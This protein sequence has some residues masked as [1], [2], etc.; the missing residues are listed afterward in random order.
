VLLTVQ[1]TDYLWRTNA[2]DVQKFRQTKLNDYNSLRAMQTFWLG[3]PKSV[4]SVAPFFVYFKLSEDIAKKWRYDNG[5]T[6]TFIESASWIAT[7]HNNVIM[8]NVDIRPFANDSTDLE[9][10]NDNINT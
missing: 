5:H 7:Y 8:T 6:F 1:T 4:V 3:G 10:Y 2:Y 9:R